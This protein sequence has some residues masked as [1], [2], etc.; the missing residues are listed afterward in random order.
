MESIKFIDL[1]RRVGNVWR[2]LL[3]GSRFIESPKHFREACYVPAIS[4]ERS[5]KQRAP[6]AFTLVE[7]LVVIAIIGILVALLLPAIQAARESARRATCVN[8]MKNIATAC[9]VYESAQKKLPYGRKFNFWDTYTWTQLILPHIEEQAVYDLYWTLPDQKMVT[10]ATTPTSNG[11]IGDDARL[12]QARHSQ[13]PV[14]YCPSDVTPV[15]NEMSTGAF[16]T[17]QHELSWLC[18]SRRDVRRPACVALRDTAG[19]SYSS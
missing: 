5:S 3:L 8:K 15:P 2:R 11:P 13:I 7:L 1:V 17:W 6:R 12:R 9:L 10:P 18:G 19:D 16:G 4:V 14:Y